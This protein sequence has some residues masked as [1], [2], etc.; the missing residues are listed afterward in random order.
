MR[1]VIWFSVK[2][3]SKHLLLYLFYHQLDAQIFFLFT[4]NTLIKILHMF[5]AYSAHLQEV[6][7]VIV[8]GVQLKSGS[9][10]NMSNLFTKIYNMLYYITKMYLQ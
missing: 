2:R 1:C 8:Q 7:F 9:Y 5:R 4:Y 3:L 6:H 10:F